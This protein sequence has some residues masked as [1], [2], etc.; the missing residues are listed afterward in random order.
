MSQPELTNLPSY[1]QIPQ[2][3]NGNVSP[4]GDPA[5]NQSWYLFYGIWIQPQN[6][7]QLVHQQAVPICKYCYVRWNL[8]A[9]L[10]DSYLHHV[11][12]VFDK[13]RHGMK[14]LNSLEDGIPSLVSF[15][16]SFIQQLTNIYS[17]PTAW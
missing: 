11:Q 12:I 14:D 8:F 13:V 16:S 1:N 6:P 17:G 7:S 10:T 9:I 3:Y 15:I 2:N 4:T 5:T